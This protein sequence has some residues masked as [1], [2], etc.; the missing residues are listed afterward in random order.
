V[1]ATQRTVF[2]KYRIKQQA[3]RHGEKREG[4]GARRRRRRQLER[5]REGDTRQCMCRGMLV[6]SAVA[7]SVR[8]HFQFRC[9]S[10]IYRQVTN[11]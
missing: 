1:F 9:P 10:A 3:E 4:D 2:A 5:E 8:R 11:C 6:F 7:L